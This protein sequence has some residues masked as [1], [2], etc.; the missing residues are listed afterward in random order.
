MSDLATLQAEIV[1]RDGAVPMMLPAVAY[2]S[3]EVLAWELRHV[4]AGTWTCLGRLEELLAEENGKPV[5]QR[6]A[7]VGDVQVLLTRADDGVRMFANTCRHRGHELLEVG[8]TST[9]RAIVCPYH[10]WSYDLGGAWSPRPASGPARLRPGVHGLVE[11]PVEVWSGELGMFGHA[12][13]PL[14]HTGWAHRSGT[15]PSCRSPSTSADLAGIGRAV[16]PGP[17]CGSPTWDRRTY[18]VSGQLEDRGRELPR[19]STTAR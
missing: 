16:P 1:A 18:E 14:G 11:L 5:T 8:A 3:E 10:A 4:Y 2:T 6:A 12:V 7:V 17:T 15:R 9:R 13:H 19:V